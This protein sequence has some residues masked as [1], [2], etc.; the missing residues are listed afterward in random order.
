MD[1]GEGG[2]SPEPGSAGLH[3]DAHGQPIPMRPQYF[4]IGHGMTVLPRRPSDFDSLDPT[5]AFHSEHSTGGRAV[6]GSLS[7]PNWGTDASGSSAGSRTATMEL[8]GGGAEQLIGSRVSLLSQHELR[9]E[10]TLHAVDAADASITMRNGKEGRKERRL[11]NWAD[12]P[13]GFNTIF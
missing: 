3:V 4:E 13:R 2:G 8:T 9:Y 11:S 5:R 1:T 6:I 7:P 10:G 12:K